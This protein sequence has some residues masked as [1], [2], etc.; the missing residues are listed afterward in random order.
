[1]RPPGAKVW[2][3]WMMKNWMAVLPLDGLMRNMHFMHKGGLF[4]FKNIGI[5]ILAEKH[6]PPGNEKTSPPFL[7][8]ILELQKVPTFRIGEFLVFSFPGENF[9]T[10]LTIRR[11]V[12]FKFGGSIFVKPKELV[13]F[14]TLL[15]HQT[16]PSL[17]WLNTK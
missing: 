17:S 13:F 1:M 8:K 5:F 3:R 4:H 6:D 2:G 12:S 9:Q 10:M 16:R 15:V 7:G 11:F 14:G